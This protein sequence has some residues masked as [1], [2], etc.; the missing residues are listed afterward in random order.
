MLLRALVTAATIGLASSL[1]AAKDVDQVA[2]TY[3]VDHPA[4]NAVNG[5]VDA[6]GDAGYVDGKTMKLI[7][8]SAQGSMPT[9]LQIAKQFAGEK[10]D[11]MVAIST[12]W[13][14]PCK[15]PLGRRR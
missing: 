8:Q 5:I 7:V 9:Q 10:P 13:R 3:I 11:L 2:L 15:A 4:I 1:A 6:L 14:K 12:P